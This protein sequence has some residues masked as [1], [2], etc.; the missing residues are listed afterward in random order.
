M[1][2]ARRNAVSD[3]ELSESLA[4]AICERVMPWKLL[5]V[6]MLRHLPVPQVSVI[7]DLAKIQR[8]FF[9]GKEHSHFAI[10]HGD[11]LSQVIVGR[12]TN[13]NVVSWALM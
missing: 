5:R 2:V 9:R 10:K 1:N 8:K 13:F 6:C 4:E 7:E 11:I 12:P 3:R